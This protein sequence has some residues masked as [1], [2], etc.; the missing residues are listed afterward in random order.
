M[1][2][3]PLVSIVIPIK[4]YKYIEH[5][6][7]DLKKQTFK[8]FEMIVLDSNEP[9]SIKRNLG[10]KKS[11]GKL[12]VFIDDDVILHPKW[13]EELVKNHRK[14]KV[15]MGSVTNTW[16]FG[17]NNHAQTCNCIFLKKNYKPFDESFK[18]AAYEDKDW[19][20]KMGGV[21]V[22]PHAILFHIDQQKSSFRKNFIFGAESVKFDMIWRDRTEH[23]SSRALYYS[24]RNSLLEISHALGIIYGV[25]K[26]EIVKHR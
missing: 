19:F 20:Y 21:D 18:Y 7:A 17:K 13:L 3:K 6:K 23:L 24:I 26:Y 14:D 4:N 1:T 10:V 9:V 12:I 2:S 8:N 16:K 22:V 25:M 5:L 15:V 11:R